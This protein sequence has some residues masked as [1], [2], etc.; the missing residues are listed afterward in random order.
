[1]SKV[2]L[3]ICLIFSLAQTANALDITFKPSCSVAD[4]VIKFGDVATFNEETDMTQAL[5][6]LPIGQ[7]PSPG[8]K[9]NLSSLSIKE[10]LVA[11]QTLPANIVWTGSPTVTI[12][13]QGITLGPDDIQKII[14][15]FIKKSSGNLPDA[16]IRFIPSSLPLPFT[17]P[18]GDLTHEV[19]PSNPDIISS[20]RISI[21]FR[22]DDR[23]V[24]NMSVQGKVEALAPV[25][26]STGRLKRGHI[27]EPQDLTT[28]MMDMSELSSPGMDI[29]NFIGKRLERSLRAG[30]PV[31]LSM[32]ETLPIVRR[33]DRVKMVIN[34]GRMR[35]TA[36]GLARSDGIL[37]E[38]IRVQNINSNKIIHCRVA[39]PG[40][41]EVIL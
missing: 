39:A 36:T 18:F 6:T 31:L 1:M 7:A 21:I 23:V 9:I 33:G 35:L 19:I 25:V 14:A 20:S 11:S 37:D 41:V 17:L 5:A 8:D 2:F 13:R 32:V 30:A 15:Q 22:I 28:T 40:L 26:V 3:I 29:D 16:E 38:M 27:L 34:S 10:Y 4:S 24:K 12:Q